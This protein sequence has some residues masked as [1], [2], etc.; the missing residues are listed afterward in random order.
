MRTARERSRRWAVWR[1]PENTLGRLGCTQCFQA[2]LSA[3]QAKGS[4]KTGLR[5]FAKRK[6]QTKVSGCLAVGLGNP[7]C[8]YWFDVFRF[9]FFLTISYSQ[10]STP[11]KSM[12]S[13]VLKTS[14]F[15]CLSISANVS[16]M[17][18]HFCLIAAEMIS[19]PASPLND[20]P[21]NFLPSLRVNSQFLDKKQ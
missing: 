11:F 16:P 15:C 4:L 20:T 14:R 12:F 19:L 8:A 10:A 21:Q 6:R 1:Q 17:L 13:P 9:F 7:T 2:T 3:A 18:C 5:A